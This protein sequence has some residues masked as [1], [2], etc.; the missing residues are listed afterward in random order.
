MDAIKNTKTDPP[1]AQLDSAI[2]S[3]ARQIRSVAGYTV[4]LTC[5]IAAY[6]KKRLSTGLGHEGDG[7]T[8]KAMADLLE[9]MMALKSAS[10]VLCDAIVKRCEEIHPTP[11]GVGWN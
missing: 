6:D 4:D 8:G 7:P 11:V 5:E 9:S 1:T 2:L 10:G 3:I